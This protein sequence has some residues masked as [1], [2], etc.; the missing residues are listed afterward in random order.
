MSAVSAG[1]AGRR[2]GTGGGTC[3]GG[4]TGRGA[5]TVGVKGLVRATGGPP[6]VSGTVGAV[7]VAV[8]EGAAPVT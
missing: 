1:P 4:G 6:L 7:P 2:R 3:T 5:C 8:V